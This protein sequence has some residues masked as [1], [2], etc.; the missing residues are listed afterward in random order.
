MVFL[1]FPPPVDPVEFETISDRRTG[2]PIAS[3]IVRLPPQQ[4]VQSDGVCTR[5][6][7]GTCRIRGQSTQQQ[8]GKGVC[9][10]MLPYTGFIPSN[11]WG[12]REQKKSA[13]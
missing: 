4:Y 8:R 1:I 9:L 12:Y 10:Y 7:T 5:C 2:K 13:S 3:R 6:N 11:V